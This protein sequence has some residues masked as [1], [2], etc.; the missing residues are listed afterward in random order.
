V[1]AAPAFESAPSL[2]VIAGLPYQYDANAIDP[3]G[4]VLS[5]ELLV[6]PSGLTIDPETGLIE[7]ETTP[8]DIANH[9]VVLQASDGRGGTALQTF[10]LAV[11]EEPPNR[12]PIFTST[13]EVDAWI[14]QLYQYDADAIDPDQDPLTYSLILGPEGMSIHPD[15]GEV[16]WT[17]PAIFTLG[18]TVL[19]QLRLPG[20]QDEFIFSG[21]PGQRLYFDI[22]QSSGG[23]GDWSFSVYSPSGEKI[24]A[25]N[26]ASNH[27]L[28][29]NESGNYRVVID[30]AGDHTGSYGLS[31]IDLS[32]VP[33]APFDTVIEGTLNPGTEDDI[34]RFSGNAGQKLFFDKL[35]NSGD[36]D[37]ILYDENNQIVER[38]FSFNDM[39]LYLPADGEYMLALRGQS[40]FTE[41]VD[42][43][44]EIITPEEITTSLNLGNNT[45]PN[46][47]ASEI[48]EKGEEDFYIFTG[49][50]GQRLY[51]DR[52]FQDGTTPSAHT[53]SIISPSGQTVFSHNLQHA[54]DP[55]PII[56]EE[57]GTYRVRID[58][59]GEHTGSYSFSLL[60]LD[61][62]TPINPDTVYSGTLD[63]G[64]E[65]HLYQFSGSEGQR[66]YLDSPGDIAGA[67]G[68]TLYDSR[69]QFI[70]GSSSLNSDQEIV[71]TES[72]IYTLVIDGRNG[73]TPIDYSFEVITPDEVVDSLIIDEIVAGEI[74]EKGEQDLYTFSGTQ[75]QR[76]FL[77]TLQASTALNATLVSPSGQSLFNQ[78]GFTQESGRHPVI[79]PEDG[80]YQL[81]VD[82]SQESRDT[83]RFQLVD[84]DAAPLLSPE[85]L[86][87]SSLDPGRLLQVY[88]LTGN[89]GDRVYFENQANSSNSNHWRLYSSGNQPLASTTLQQDFE[90][91]LPAS[92]TY[93][94]LLQG[95]E[96]SPVPYEIQ[97]VPT[98]APASPLVLNTSIEGDIGKL[99]EQDRYTFNG[100][101]GQTL[102]FVPRE[103]D[104]DITVEIYNPSGNLVLGGDT[105]SDSPPL[106][107]TEAGEY[108][109]IVDGTEEAT[110]SYSFLLA[111]TAPPLFPAT[112][113][114]GTLD[115]GEVIFYQFD[116]SRGQQLDFE[117]LSAAPGADWILYASATLPG[118]TQTVGTASLNDSFTSV[119][120]VEGR[121]IL[122]LRNP[123]DE[124]VDYDVQVNDISAAVVPTAGLDTLYN[125]TISTGGEVDVYPIDANAGSL[126]LFDGQ[127]N[128][129]SQRVRL[130]NP[131]GTLVFSNLDNRNDAGPYPLTQTGSYSLEVYGQSSS[132]TGDY[133]FQLVELQAAP[134][135]TLNDPLDV[136]LAAKETKVFQFNGSAGQQLWLDGL[137]TS[138]PRVTATV[139]NASGHPL[140][141]IDD[142]R[143]DSELLTLEA[144]G[145][146]YLVL[147]SD[148]AAA[149]TASFRLLDAAAANLLTPDSDISGDF[150]SSRRETQLYRFSGSEDQR[151]YFESVI[152]DSG[153]RYQLYS[154]DGQRLFSRGLSSDFE[155]A[156]LPSDG[157]YILAL[158]G[159]GRAN[160][161]YS[162]RAIAP[163]SS[164]LPL[165]IGDT[166]T[167]E[168]AEVGEQTTYTFEGSANQRLFFDSLAAGNNVNA[169]LYS[170]TG[171]QVWQQETDRDGDPTLLT[172][173]GTYRLVIDG[174]DDT[175]NPYSFR[176]LDLAAATATDL[177]S[178]IA[179]NLG[180][181]LREAHLYRFNGSAGQP[182]FFNRTVGES[183]GFTGTN[184]YALYSPDGG[185]LFNRGLNVDTETILPSDGEYVL[186]VGGNGNPSPDYA[187]E[188]VTPER[189]A[190]SPYIIGETLSNAISEAGEQDTF[191]FTGT[192]G[193]QLL[194]D[195]LLDTDN[196]QARLIAPSGDVVWEQQSL[197][198][199]RDPFTLL[200][201]GTYT[202]EIDGSGEA[203]GDYSFR[204]L[205]L[206][207][208]TAIRL[209]EAVI[210]DFGPSLREAEIYRFSADAGQRL[211]FDR[212]TGDGLNSYAL[213]DEHGQQLFSQNLALDFEGNEALLPETGDYTLVFYGNGRANNTYHLAVLTPEII[214]S[215]HQIGDVLSGEIS[216][217][218][219]QDIYTFEGTVGQQLWFDSLENSPN[220]LG[221]ELLAPNGEV[222]LNQLLSRDAGPIRL[223]ADGTYRIIVDD[224]ADATSS[225]RFRWLDAATAPPLPLD[226]PVTGNFGSN[227]R[228]TQLYR[229]TGN[230]GQSL[231]FDSS[232][233]HAF[234]FYTLY[235]PD[236]EQIFSSPLPNDVELELEQTG[237]Y[238]LTINGSSLSAEGYQLTA[239]TPVQPETPLILGE[240]ITSRIDEFGEQ[241]TYTFTGTVG[242]QL[243]FDA[244]NGHLNLSA[245]LYSPSGKQVEDWLTDRDGTPVT[246]TEAGPYRLVLDGRG[247]A[248]GDYQFRLWD[249][250]EAPPLVLGTTIEDSLDSAKATALYQFSGRQG[251]VLNFD[252][253]ADQ[254]QGSRWVLYDPDNQVIA[255]PAAD[256]PDFDVA[257]PSSGLY[258]LAIIGSSAPVDYRFEA[259]DIT[260]APV[261]NLNLNRTEDG[262]LAAGEVVRFPFT[263]KAGTQIL[264]NDLGTTNNNIQARL[265][266]PDGS[267][268]FRDRANLDQ[269]PLVLQQS[270]EYVLEIAGS[271]AA[272][273][274]NY[275]FQLLEFP[276]NLRDPNANYL[277]IGEVV[278]GA[279]DG[280][281]A[282]LYSFQGVTGLQLLLNGITG[283]NVRATLYNPNGDP[284]LLTNLDRDTS[285]HTLSQ[286]GL[287]H[288]VVEG[289][290]SGTQDFSFQVLEPSNADTVPFN[291]PVSGS[292][293]SGQQ[294]RFYQFEGSAGERLFFDSITGNFSNRWKL[295]GPDQ[296]LLNTEVLARDFELELPQD[297]T[298]QLLIQGS[299][300]A[301]PV[302]YEFRVLPH[303]DAVGVDA[304]VPGTGETLGNEVASLGQFTVK[305]GVEDGQGGS[306]IQEYTLRLWPDP[307][308]TNPTLLS[309]PVIHFGL[310]QEFYRYQLE[311]L[312]ADGDPL[313]Y[314]LLEAPLGALI[315][316]DTGELLWFPE[317]G[318]IAPGDTIQFEVEVTD[319]RG[320]SDRQQFAV[321]VVDGLGTIQGAVFDDLNGNGFRDSELVSGDDPA[322]VLAI[323]I[324]GSTGAPF[325]GPDGVETVLD[326]QVAATLALVDSLVGQ[327][328]GDQVNI[329]LIPHN[330]SAVIQDMDPVTPGVQP[331]TTPL[332]DRDGD[333]VPDIRQIL[334]GYFPQER[335]NFTETIETI[336]ELVNLLPGDPNVI[337]LSDGYGPLDETVA[338]EVVGRLQDQGVNITG[339]GVGEY[340]RLSTIQKIDP[341]AIQIRDVE[342]LVELFA[343]WDPRYTTE[344]LLENVA[345]YLD[346]NDNGQLDADE[347]WQLT[348]EPEALNSS[349]IAVSNPSHFIFE[350]L[351]PGTYTL[352]QVVPSGFDQTTPTT[353]AYVDT[354]TIT[355]ET[356]NRWFGVH[357]G[358]TE[359]TNQDPVFLSED[360]TVQLQAGESFV[361]QG[362]ALD[363]DS[364]PL[365]Y[366]LTLNPE[367]MTVDPETGWVVWTPTAEQVAQYYAELEAER[368]R[369]AA[370]G[371]GDVVSDTVTFDVFLR[372]R[373]GQG[374]QALQQIQIEVLP[375]NTPP[376][377]TSLIPEDAMPQIGKPFQYQATAIDADGDTVTYA[378][379]AGAPAGV[380]IDPQTGLVSWTP[381]AAQLGDREITIIARD[382]RSGVSTQTVPLQV[383][384]AAPNRDPAIVSRPRTAVRI[385]N[386]YLYQLQA[387]DPDG[388]PLDFTLVSAPV[389]MT[390]DEEDNLIWTPTPEQFGDHT[391]EVLVS[392]GQGGQAT[393]RFTLNASHQVANHP[394]SITSIPLTLTHLDRLYQYPLTGFD[395]DGDALVWSLLQAPAGMVIDATTGVVSWQPTPEQIGEHIIQVELQDALG[396]SSVQEFTLQVTGINTPPKIVSVPTT[397]AAQE[398]SYTY[399]V[400]ATDPEGDPLH[401]SL[402]VRPDGMTIDADTGAITWTPTLE[403]L[404]EHTVEVVVMDELGGSNRQTFT[405]VVGNT[406]INQAPTI[407]ST[408]IFQADSQQPYVYELTATDPD[409][410]DLTFELI[411]AP[412]GVTIDAETGDLVWAEPVVGSHQL[413]VGASDGQLGA[414]QGFTLTVQE[415]QPPLVS[416]LPGTEALAGQLYSYDVQA[417]DPNGDALTYMLDPDSEALGMTLDEAGRLRWTPTSEQLGNY[418]VTV[419]VTD[420]LGATVTQDFEVAVTADTQAPR[421]TL[422]VGNVTVTPVGFE[423][424]LGTEVTF[425][426]LAVDD[427]EVEG[428]QLFIDDE[429]VQLDAYGLA[430]VTLASAGTVT[431]RAVATDTSGNQGVASTAVLALD[432]TDTEGP[433][434]SLDISHIEDGVITAPTDILGTVVD[435]NLEGYVLE[436]APLDG[437]SPF[438]EIARGT[439]EVSA[440]VLGEFD[441]TLLLNDSYR[442]RLTARDAGGNIAV[443]EEVVHV[444]GDLKLGNFQLSFTDL[445]VPVSGIPIQ[446]VRTYDSLAANRTDELGYGWR[447][448]FRDTDLRTSIGRD[449]QYE[450]LG[451]PS[452]AF[453][454]GTKVFVTLPGGER[455]SF[456]FEPEIDPEIQAL[457]DQG[458]PIPPGLILYNPKFVAE[459]GSELTLSVQDETLIRNSDT[460]EFYSLSGY[461]YNPA[462]SFFG[463]TYMLTTEDGIEYEIDGESGDL[464]TATDPN[465]N[466]LT[467]TDGGIFSDTGRDI[468]F[469]RDAQNRIVAIIDPEGNRIEYSYDDQG[470]LA[471][472]ADREGNVT[473]FVYDVPDRPHYLNEIIDPLGRSGVRTE[474]DSDGRLSSLK[475]ASGQTIGFS[476][477]PDNQLE[478]TTDPLGNTTIFE[479]DERG[480]TLQRQDALGGITKFSYDEDNN[481]LSETDALGNTT[482][483]TYDGQGNL[484]STTDPLGNTT[485]YAYDGS[486]NL[487]TLTDPLGN[488]TTYT[489]DRFGNP[490]SATDALGN[491]SEMTLN[492]QGNP[493][494]VSF[495]GVEVGSFEFNEFGHGVKSID[496]L[497]NVTSHVFDTKGN[498]LKESITVTTPDGIQTLETDYE[499]NA[500]GQMTAITDP[501][502][503]TTRMEYDDLGRETAIIDSS[504]R[505]TE[506]EYDE[507]GNLIAI[508]YADGS[509]ESMLYDAIGQLIA[510][511]DAI[512]RTTRYEYD[513]LGRQTAIIHPDDTPDDLSDNLRQLVEYDAIGQV[514][515]EVD[516][517]GNRVEYSYDVAG[518]LSSV[519]VEGFVT[520][521]AYD[522]AG[523]RT[524]ETNSLGQT[525][526]YV[527]DPNGILVETIYPDGTSLSNAGTFGEGVNI[528]DADGNMTSFET[529]A[530]NELTAVVDALGQRT[531][532]AYDE[533]GN[534]ISQ[535]DANGNVTR[536][537]YNSVG[538]R[539][540]VILPDGKRSSIEYDAT[541]NP[542]QSID[543]NGAVT[544]YEYDDLNRISRVIL[545]DG[546][547]LGYT[548]DVA[549]QLE[550]ITDATGTTV[551][552]YDDEGRLISR[553]TPDGLTISYAYG[554]DGE[555][556]V[557]SP[558]GTTTYIYDD[559]GRLL[560]VRDSL[561]GTVKYRYEAGNLVE[562]ELANGTVEKRRYNDLN[563]LI[564]LEHQEA[565]GSILLSQTF[566]RNRAGNIL[567]VEENS[568]RIVEYDYDVLGRLIGETITDSVEGDRTIT[569]TYDEVGNRLERNDSI[570]GVTAYTYNSRN[571]L[572]SST[573]DGEVTVYA[574]DDNGNRIQESS[575]NIST[576]YEWDNLDR[577]I[578][579]NTTEGGVTQTVEYEYNHEGIRTAKIVDGERTEYLIDVLQPYVQV[580]EEYRPDGSVVSYTHGHGAGPTAQ[581]HSDLGSLYYHGDHLDS[582]RFLT[583]GS[584]EGT[585]DRY[586]Y[587]AYGRILTAAGDSGVNHLYTGEPF[588]TELGLQYL[589]DRFL[590]VE[591]GIFVRADKFEGLEYLP[592]TRHPYLYAS[593]NPVA[594]TDPSGFLNLGE[595]NIGRIMQDLVRRIKQS[596]KVKRFLD[597]AGGATDLFAVVGTILPLGLHLLMMYYGTN[598][599]P[600]QGFAAQGNLTNPTAF[601]KFGFIKEPGA[602]QQAD[603]TVEFK[604]TDALPG[605]DF[606]KPFKIKGVI[607]AKNTPRFEGSVAFSPETGITYG[608]AAVFNGFV[609]K[610]PKE[611]PK[612]GFLATSEFV[613]GVSAIA[614][615]G[616]FSDLE[617]TSATRLQLAFKA[618]YI[619]SLKWTLP[620][621]SLTWYTKP[622]GTTYHG[623]FGNPHGRT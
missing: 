16:E 390:L 409:G 570:E 418:P 486:G 115:A 386:S 588:D 239:V 274:G 46:P 156:A 428:L 242:Q 88:Q 113:L 133:Q 523:R 81:I 503:R 137:N 126:I 196:L 465:G 7:W 534:L 402:G 551:Q 203:T 282:T 236:G 481:I 406:P 362:R 32:L 621:L 227:H 440:D 594:F 219:E 273:S 382:G 36:L 60:D 351:L 149:T 606:I 586:L 352:R 524:S 372:A 90:T 154:P 68:W 334:E 47:I 177:D 483:F 199:D 379:A 118:D 530:K 605:P 597:L 592:I 560:E 469:E 564:E 360:P 399:T 349:A 197:D 2:E 237:Q 240:T 433:Q 448:E 310:N 485:H 127:G 11:I 365:S 446:V 54:G 444:E 347:P 333:G 213:Y 128:D 220:S 289:E 206:A 314:R 250:A 253:D 111:D 356:I 599:S 58:G 291:V 141:T 72:E 281:E 348:Q 57:S 106:V 5:Y 122:A 497:G 9:A 204:L 464:L 604:A 471:A 609:H 572:T 108:E 30:G 205:D 22:L 129:S 35:S 159:A 178:E 425:Q 328:L 21:S 6:A 299:S 52:L 501:E 96:D 555:L 293:A 388:D 596:Q 414:A 590:D 581:H 322:I 450:I 27:L 209:D 458:A 526:Q 556:S 260:P 247:T 223:P 168:I 603:V 33:N 576:V 536:Y 312:D 401:F 387:T 201:A 181:S 107:L 214:E 162:L 436:V 86:T 371:R 248:T 319:G 463:G 557:I 259:T 170:P 140:A 287:Y 138:D 320:G 39:E 265:V 369:L 378:L 262:T 502:G 496:P 300:N 578:K 429:P 215:A 417:V 615:I 100:N 185:T 258:T 419:T 368:Q 147:Q 73:T 120:P 195:S 579:A 93:Y 91:V 117:S 277:E 617:L 500:N 364:D 613:I 76:L 607:D 266:N 296:N 136:S 353:D 585:A 303:P 511:T 180:P 403:Q 329:G 529:N 611:G 288:L 391:I 50:P 222:L 438:V 531:E 238:T 491:V 474:Y 144:E 135:L 316:N 559:V 278:S 104:S 493:T 459:D 48:L 167:G 84:L 494:S 389:G 475:D 507:A 62:A 23:T 359:L 601:A 26:L 251:Q 554:A 405:L 163:A 567:K 566:T 466:Q 74:A 397:Q 125:D 102:Y 146:Y 272:V 37:W 67:A 297:G 271:S 191:T 490:T 198:R 580:R 519:D 443:T 614:N 230:Q 392:D 582:T 169:I 395:L 344:P 264:F 151:L 540:A 510:T 160:N 595:V 130:F 441:P 142:L 398:Q 1:N 439:D 350:N 14:N 512:G 28:N 103:G 552:A 241:D 541:G 173:E 132:S 190:P 150:G 537:E 587:D 454:E 335:N 40:G 553:T 194:F 174:T 323:D 139:V 346:L 189:L 456:T 284:V 332:A 548:Y 148:N 65:T 558:T 361:F 268:V 38:D 505:R 318:S 78:I 176:L 461:A 232:Q 208:A 330:T 243:Y 577:L 280:K 520:T 218:G 186:V 19:G 545:E 75:G 342:E 357:A 157:E 166:I 435:D 325:P 375:D 340:S 66:L 245:K 370:I 302:D 97:W 499:Y 233:G 518:Q 383:I 575:D 457:L 452:K 411:A 188:I 207:A 64:Q 306:D 305:L 589:R 225:Y 256:N 517:N 309:E 255:A 279:L 12:P 508:N 25:S 263:A 384:E 182:L 622:S 421:V 89:E 13:P 415:N 544:L 121:Y 562:T 183:N 134:D 473:Q 216:E 513:A 283:R 394:P 15:S 20:E 367:G 354:V 583:D 488:T 110:G 298:Y 413:V 618:S 158:I 71:L 482:S 547:E 538:L 423:A 584:G 331:Y 437:S 270:G 549:G 336:E 591:N 51:F 211:Y 221:L 87:S 355:G 226:T 478:I 267:E 571:Q 235:N 393:Q 193:Q 315:D 301:A 381:T 506:F 212:I 4:D 374:G 373:D 165:T 202:L 467:F 155:I 447:L 509:Q 119:L 161:N 184:Y 337:Y 313:R 616:L 79:L 453:K 504:G 252:L 546:S 164:E 339:F 269:G 31:A 515:A 49:Q 600:Q 407:T 427:V 343:G 116:G 326:A 275:Q 249:R 396:A 18:D 561:S 292:L 217:A 109:L 449:E 228:E 307:D 69:N 94:L 10:T 311:G 44:F 224:T 59:A 308:N 341:A 56:L 294:S 521:F 321:Q 602:I 568:G 400:V 327:G 229:F 63:P 55:S 92:G 422:Q 550:R 525:T 175:T 569:Y 123:A 363:P 424:D 42:Y 426:V 145:D 153:N 172:E 445:Q 179:G 317:A 77:D 171:V 244:L 53:A 479:Y 82:G 290:R 610:V 61:L 623:P 498:V 29:L 83:Y 324:S 70:R 460:G 45:N 514:I 286:D 345:V 410:D 434:V 152:G 619:S 85:T 8:D 105:G 114:T 484:L 276:D 24:L 476:Y 254:W 295:Y 80:T 231:Y 593:A 612:A 41:I 455:T 358:D 468:T 124:S 412:P 99:G 408:P 472:V 462:V 487:L 477:D 539:T 376:A 257:L 480:N 542:A 246:L 385:G 516:A 574:Y 98:T 112:R 543:F 522:E 430:T 192:P 431:A 451:I 470:N 492:A 338:A 261:A 131:D 43:A 210:D 404:G 573:H 304:I 420:A 527:Y 200:E 377:F 535:T 563:Q 533:L 495:Q 34:Y 17:P 489:Y 598:H 143:N 608:G 380:T 3:N 565:N 432:P 234:D 532:Y 366:D 416:S 187:L 442:L 101:V 95:A 620:L 528:T 285:L